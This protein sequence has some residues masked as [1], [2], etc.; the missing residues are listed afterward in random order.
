MA[1]EISVLTNLNFRGMLCRRA[2]AST[3]A[4]LD[5]QAGKDVGLGMFGGK[6]ILSAGIRV[7]QL[8]ENS[9]RPPYRVP[10]RAREISASAR[11]GAQG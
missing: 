6:S 7:A 4:I 5:F 11:S 2:L 3:H 8:N 10:L 1:K 9:E